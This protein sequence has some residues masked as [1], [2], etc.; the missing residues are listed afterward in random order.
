MNKIR[1]KVIMTEFKRRICEL[2][3]QSIAYYRRNPCIAAKDL[4][5]VNLFDAQKYMLQGT[6]NA[7]HAVWCCSRNFGKSFIGVVFL[8]LKAILYENQNIY[9]ISSVG[10]QAKET[11]VKLEELVLRLGK[12][13]ASIKSLKDIVEKETVKSSAS[14]TGFIHDP[15][16][17]KVSFY[18]GSSIYTL[19]SKPDNARSRRANVVFFDEAAFCS[20][21]LIAVCE[22][23][24]T[25]NSEFVTSTDD[26]Y[27]PDLEPRQVPTQLVYASSQSEMDKIFYKNYK[28]F[29]KQMIAG[30]R[31]YFVVD[32]ICDVAIEPYMNG[33]SY[34]P[35]LTRSKVDAA[36]KADKDKALREYYNKPTLDGGDAQIIKWS[37][38]RRNECFYLPRLSFDGVEKTVM[39]FDPARTFDNSIIGV[40]KL[41]ED[42][43]LG[44]CG[45]ISNCVSLIDTASR[46]KYKLDSNR[47]IEEIRS[48]LLAYNGD[49]PDYEFID[50]L[51][52]D[53]GAGGGGLSTYAD[54]L[55]HDWSDAAGRMHRG[56]IDANNDVYS[57]YQGLYPNAV[58]KLRLISPRKLKAQMVREMI[59]L[60][61]L[62]VLRF[63]YEYNGSDF[64]QIIR[65]T[66]IDTEETES[67]RLHDEEK[68]ALVQLDLMKSEITSIHRYTNSENTTEV[69]ALAKD[70][71]HSMHDDRFY[72]A[73]MLAHRLYEL[74]RGIVL[75][76]QAD[77]QK[78]DSTKF[79]YRRPTIR[80][81]RR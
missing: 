3:A 19:N 46:K 37:A 72:V 10:D 71:E 38:I 43:K 49:N 56:L 6:W 17:Y 12:T 11:F 75:Q 73:I 81:F 28:N 48:M 65:H 79:M 67:Y 53:Q 9:I 18:N 42:P 4:L 80:G 1:K 76:K 36:L 41:V 31:D 55:L 69:F 7:S 5:G 68:L 24:A 22:A 66:G 39:A 45:N 64:I 33:K 40:M 25:Q 61:E 54:G 59:E 35:L 77:L 74:R 47:Q 15:R 2:D 27:D 29:A 50:S 57:G 14:K 34:T 63:P 51:L 16:G 44:L 32:M 23:F 70:K 26:N 58:N 20:D 62:G 8:V 13:S 21:E 30:N 52:I 60:V 78:S